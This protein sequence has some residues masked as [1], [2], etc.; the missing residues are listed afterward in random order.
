MPKASCKSPHDLVVGLVMDLAVYVICRVENGTYG[1]NLAVFSINVAFACHF[2][3]PTIPTLHHYRS[4]CMLSIP[5]NK[6]SEWREIQLA[7][8]STLVHK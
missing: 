5:V 7:I 1:H 4:V 2:V 3:A 8:H 6:L